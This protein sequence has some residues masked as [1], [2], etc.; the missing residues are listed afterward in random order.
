MAWWLAAAVGL[1]TLA[2]LAVRRLS[3]RRRRRLGRAS[4]SPLYLDDEAVEDH[5]KF[6]NHTAALEKAVEERRSRSVGLWASLPV[7]SWF[8]AKRD[9]SQEVFVSYIQE[10]EPISVVGML[11]SVFER[12]D[13]IVHVRLR[14]G[15]VTPN[16]A[17]VR[18]L[19]RRERDEGH[20]DGV[21]LSEIGEF[22]MVEAK[23]ESLP[24][25]D[26][27]QI[28]KA[29]YRDGERTAHL[30]VVLRA[31]RLRSADKQLPSGQFQARCLGKITSW[32]PATG[33]TVLEHPI[34]VFR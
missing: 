32:N 6:G 10:S 15:T 8:T 13:A 31:D 3:A 14:S 19:A 7:V 4:Y 9:S 5:Y 22:V 21:T 29:V 30:R 33:E 27:A 25:D 12:E 34:A 1:V 20:A 28:M 17:L 24:G 23:F 18:E 26:K 2:V 16:R 11:L